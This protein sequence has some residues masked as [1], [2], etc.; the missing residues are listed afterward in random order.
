MFASITE[1]LCSYFVAYVV[2]LF[3]GTLVEGGRGELTRVKLPAVVVLALGLGSPG[4][5]VVLPN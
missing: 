1:F 5:G 3:L 4:E 2:G